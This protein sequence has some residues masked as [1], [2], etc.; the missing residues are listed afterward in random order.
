MQLITLLGLG[1]KSDEIIEIL[2]YFDLSVVYDFDRLHEGTDD[3]Y[4]ASAKRA[5]FELGFGH[6]QVL[7]TIFM[8]AAPR[9]GFSAFDHSLAGVP[10]HQSLEEAVRVFTTASTPYQTGQSWIKGRF[11][12]YALHYEFE[13]GGALALVTVMARQ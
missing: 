3:R 8:Y 12:E 6:D 5:G 11:D 2:E 7:E 4:W 9:S 10:F 13:S 1:L